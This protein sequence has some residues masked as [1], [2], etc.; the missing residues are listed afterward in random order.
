MKSD[1]A[2]AVQTA[3]SHIT[4]YPIFCS[5]ILNGA[6]GLLAE[7]ETSIDVPDV[8]SE[9]VPKLKPLCQSTCMI[10]SGYVA[11]AHRVLREAELSTFGRHDVSRNRLERCP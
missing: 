3:T 7:V 5:L 10:E 1:G 6:V 9:S 4:A 11:R 8:L 2:E